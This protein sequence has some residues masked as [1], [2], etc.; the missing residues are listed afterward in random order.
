MVYEVSDRLLLAT[1]KDMHKRLSHQRAEYG[2][3]GMQRAGSLGAQVVDPPARIMAFQHRISKHPTPLPISP[4]FSLSL[5][6]QLPIRTT[7]Q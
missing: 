1:I 4:P 6:I 2:L 7:L 3:G 5:G